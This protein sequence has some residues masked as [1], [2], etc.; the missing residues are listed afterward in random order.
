M[1]VSQPGWVDGGA[2]PRESTRSGVPF[3]VSR[4]RSPDPS[5]AAP[6]DIVFCR[7]CDAGND[8]NPRVCTEPARPLYKRP[9]DASGDPERIF[10]STSEVRFPRWAINE[11]QS[12]PL[13]G[14][15]VQSQRPRFA[16]LCVECPVID[17]GV[18]DALVN[19]VSMCYYDICLGRGKIRE[20]E[21][22]I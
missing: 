15:V 9:A 2:L 3:V 10:N 21:Q 18:S 19:L 4:R 20:G 17:K 11:A 22:E 8:R 7:Q 12:R 6:I 14:A 1:S 5:I 16:L 13:R